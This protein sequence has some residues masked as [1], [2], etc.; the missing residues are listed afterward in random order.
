MS[1]LVKIRP[2][3]SELECSQASSS[4]KISHVERRV[5]S[6][7]TINNRVIHCPIVIPY[8]K[9]GEDPTK[10]LQVNKSVHKLV[11]A[12]KSVMWNFMF[13]RPEP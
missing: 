2:K 7:R 8:V 11:V 6:T 9:F 12:G 4:S 1:S 3:A 10:G 5:Q 13:S